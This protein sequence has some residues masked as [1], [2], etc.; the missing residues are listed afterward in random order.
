MRIVDDLPVRIREIENIWIPAGNTGDRMAAR[1]WLPEGADQAPVPAILTYL[2]YRKR[3][4]TRAG[5]DPMHRYFA[6][7]GYACLR[8][9]M[10][11]SADSDGRMD[12]E[13][14]PQE[15]EDGKALIAWIAAQPWCSGEVGMIRGSLAGVD[16]RQ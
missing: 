3:D 9:D 14:A 8:V 1:L 10:R 4:S 13:Y 11:G 6:G 16:A 7:H 5:D 2:P 12:D 15:L